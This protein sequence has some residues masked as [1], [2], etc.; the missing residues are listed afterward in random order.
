MSSLTPAPISM[1]FAIVRPSI[2]GNPTEFENSGGAAPVPP[3]APS[4]VMKSG[5]I[6]AKDEYASCFDL[7]LVSCLLRAWLVKRSVSLQKDVVQTRRRF[8]TPVM[9]MALAS[10]ANSSGLPMHS[11]VH[12]QSTDHTAK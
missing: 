3:S 2:I 6:P 12:K 4:I 9:V 7:D 10:A 1:L 5:L 11:C 8:R